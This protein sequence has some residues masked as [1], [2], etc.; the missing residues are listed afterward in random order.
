[1]QRCRAVSQQDGRNW[2]SLKKPEQLR[3]P[4]GAPDD[5]P[6]KM[7]DILHPP[8]MQDPHCGVSSQSPLSSLQI[9]ALASR[10]TNKF[11]GK[12][13]VQFAAWQRQSST[14][15]KV[16][17]WGSELW[18]QPGGRGQACPHPLLSILG[19]QR[20][21]RRK[22]CCTSGHETARRNPYFSLALIPQSPAVTERIE[23]RADQ[24]WA[25]K[26]LTPGHVFYSQAF[27]SNRYANKNQL[28][29]QKVQPK[30]LVGHRYTW[31]SG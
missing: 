17:L 30:M 31:A 20:I 28:V 14:C 27:C 5:G 3:G 10:G 4:R 2:G 21:L 18:P 29:V 8:G 7:L 11:R 24:T 22:C 1:M 15:K 19:S 25:P 16:S 12:A 13:N 9:P 26:S 6:S 23:L